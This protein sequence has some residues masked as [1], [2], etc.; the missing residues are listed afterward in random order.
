MT[1]LVV[2]GAECQFKTVIPVYTG[3]HTTTTPSI[4]TL[5][6]TAQDC[7]T[8]FVPVIIPGFRQALE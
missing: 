3:I 4:I 5:L 8:L 2:L 6:S 1:S 7:R